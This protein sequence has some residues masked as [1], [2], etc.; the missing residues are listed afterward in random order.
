MVCFIFSYS[1][2]NFGHWVDFKNKFSKIFIFWLIP[3][4]ISLKIIKWKTVWKLL[5]AVWKVN[6][7]MYHLKPNTHVPFLN[8]HI[9]YE[10]NVKDF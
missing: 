1:I 9:F 4:A 10:K 6:G 8:S 3:K 7:E 5:C 2:S